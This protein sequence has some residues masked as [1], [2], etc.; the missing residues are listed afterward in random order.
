LFVPTLPLRCF[1]YL[2]FQHFSRHPREFPLAKGLRQQQQAAGLVT[3]NDPSGDTSK[4]N[5][6]G[7]VE[8]G[9]QPPPILFR[10]QEW[11]DW[12]ELSVA[13]GALLVVDGK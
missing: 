13:L 4:A 2:A 7:R 5:M 11:G 6:E 8:V 12:S 1:F 3:D 10:V 9:Q